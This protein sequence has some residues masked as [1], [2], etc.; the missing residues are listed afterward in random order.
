MNDS[1]RI[2]KFKA[3]RTL[4]GPLYDAGLR[5]E[6]D[7]TVVFLCS[8]TPPNVSLWA[9]GPGAGAATLVGATAAGA[10][11][12]SAVQ[13]G[14][15]AA[16]PAAAA[17]AVVRKRVKMARGAPA[18][19]SAAKANKGTGKGAAAGGVKRPRVP[20][21]G[22][23]AGGIPLGSAGGSGSASAGAAAGA[24]DGV[25]SPT[26]PKLLAPVKG[27]GKK[28]WLARNVFDAMWPEQAAKLASEPGAAMYKGARGGLVLLTQ[29]ELA[30]DGQLRGP[31]RAAKVGVVL[32]E[33]G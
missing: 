27:S 32:D 20:A 22:T 21:P 33:R 6:A 8:T 25:V 30:V 18:P 10:G 4:I 11:A 31:A 12:G 14:A 19:G 24:A 23:P 9:A 2:N 15:A 3:G 29:L 1:P 26:K 7:G 28:L 13:G 5:R 17:A 16:K